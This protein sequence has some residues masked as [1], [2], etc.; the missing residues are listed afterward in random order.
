MIFL[1]KS[2]TGTVNLAMNPRV[3]KRTRAWFCDR[4]AFGAQRTL[5][6]VPGRGLQGSQGDAGHSDFGLAAAAVN[7]GTGGHYFGA[8]SAQHLDH[9]GGAPAGCDDI[10]DNDGALAPE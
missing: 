5:G 7:D 2:E 4:Q 6:G 1:R 3:S 9:V 8:G 10:F